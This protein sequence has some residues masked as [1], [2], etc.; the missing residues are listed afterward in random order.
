MSAS[1]V[2]VGS[3]RF[4]L[5]QGCVAASWLS[6]KLSGLAYLP[7][8]LHSLWQPDDMGL[9]DGRDPPDVHSSG[10]PAGGLTL[11][12]GETEREVGGVRDGL[13]EG[14][15]MLSAVLSN[16]KHAFLSLS[17]LW[18]MDGVDA[19]LLQY[20]T[21]FFFFLWLTFVP[22]LCTVL[23]MFGP[24]KNTGIINSLI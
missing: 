5:R 9:C 19:F 17:L 11:R 22:P 14:K 16:S 2:C 20:Y 4:G 8:Q 24:W 7:C 18:R 6:L 15:V 13:M 3:A 23:V 1:D 12:E 10:L 21:F